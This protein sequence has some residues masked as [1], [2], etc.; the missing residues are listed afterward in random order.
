MAP[1][2]HHGDLGTLMVVF[3]H[4]DDEAYLAGGLMACAADAGRRV[5]CVTATRG[6]RGFADDDPRS[7]DERAAERETELRSCLAVLNVTEHHWL[8]HPDGGCADVDPDLAVGQL[9]ALLDEVR[10]DTVLTFGP[11]GQTYHPDHVTVSRWTTH[12]VRAS[13]GG[14]ALHYA[15]MTPE[16]V[17][18]LA[19]VVSLD[20][21]MMTDDPVPTVPA[22]DLSL[23]F[24][25]DDVLAARKVAALRCQAS[26]VEGLV[27]ATGIE[28][29]T[30]L[31]R[32][33]MFRAA[34][35]DDWAT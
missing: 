16:W 33:E 14:A 23:W 7:L 20:Q 25:C 3:A 21:V 15:V 35:D 34:T 30:E 24:V 4:P 19:D 1:E 18:A 9:C 12:A 22:D 2:P 13:G 5:V 11:D 17:D 10:P 32:D 6:E 31:A 8:G 27:A 29:Y 28:L 26:Q